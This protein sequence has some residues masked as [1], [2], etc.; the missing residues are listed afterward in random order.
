[1]KLI[2]FQLKIYKFQWLVLAHFYLQNEIQY[3]YSRY[4][5]KHVWGLI[6]LVYVKE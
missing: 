4:I 6:I 3:I 2:L 1:M 5:N